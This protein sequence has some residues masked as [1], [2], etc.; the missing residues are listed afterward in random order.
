MAKERLRKFSLS[1]RYI[2]D[3]ISFNNR[4]FKELISDIYRK[5]LITS[6]TTEYTSVVSYLDFFFT[7]YRL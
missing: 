3:L 4:R 1:Y 5:E 6:E 2:D 7:M